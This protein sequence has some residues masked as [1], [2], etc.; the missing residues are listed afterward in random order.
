MFIQS[1][2]SRQYTF[3]LE[4]SSREIDEQKFAETITFFDETLHREKSVENMQY[5]SEYDI[6]SSV[7][8]EGNNGLRAIVKYLKEEKKLSYSK[9]ASL[10]NRDQRTIWSA[11]NTLKPAKKQQNK[12]ISEK[13][14]KDDKETKNTFINSAVFADR[15]FSVLENAAMHLL[16][17][18]PVKETAQI[19]GRNQMTIWTVKK[20]AELKTKDALKDS[21]RKI[22]NA[23]RVSK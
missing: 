20:R 1:K 9:I 23:R 4:V 14:N 15:K 21:G 17:S 16:K 5:A 12:R 3:S 10:L 22:T 13:L 8:R 2:D 7:F 6:P 11:Y 19:L 18:Y